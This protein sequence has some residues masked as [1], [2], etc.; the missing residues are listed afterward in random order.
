MPAPPEGQPASLKTSSE[1]EPGGWFTGV[2]HRRSLEGGAVVNSER[3]E[4]RDGRGERPVGQ[5][6]G[7]PERPPPE[8]AFLSCILHRIHRSL[9][10][11]LDLAFTEIGSGRPIV[12]LPG[13][14]GSKR[15]WT[16]IAR[17]LA[18]HHRVFT[19]DL[20][21]HGESPWDS[22]HDYPSMAGDVATF[23]EAHTIPAATVLGHS[24]GGK[25]AMTLAL[26]QPELVAKL[27][28]VDIA[29]APSTANT[30]QVL[31]AM[32]DVPLHTV[33]TRSQVK[34]AMAEAVPSSGVRD[35]LALNLASGPTGLHWDINLEAL[36]RNFEDILGF[37]RF[38]AGAV[39]PNPT[40][41]IGGGRSPYIRPEH[42]AEIQRLF[43][44]ASIEMIPGAGHWVHAEAPQAFLEIV[45]RFLR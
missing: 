31:Q 25:V 2:V 36:D 19:L 41:F 29:P 13:L 14:F 43:P 17:Q 44:T 7:S 45:S 38:P 22:L 40:L 16:S 32:L 42:H 26:T 12:I 4:A 27:I 3:A 24:M 21:N 6:P 5:P 39:Y 11:P 10:V 33:T 23:L 20:R 35:F 1:G 15:N 30:R 8:T 37:P 9:P 18:E 28:V 34:E